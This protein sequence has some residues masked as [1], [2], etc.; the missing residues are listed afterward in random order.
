MYY[1]NF[2]AMD[3]WIIAIKMRKW[4][5]KSAILIIIEFGKNGLCVYPERTKT[6]LKTTRSLISKCFEEKLLTKGVSSVNFSSSFI[7]S[8]YL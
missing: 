5:L 4:N 8:M 7:P 1:V 6:R 3:I 2:T